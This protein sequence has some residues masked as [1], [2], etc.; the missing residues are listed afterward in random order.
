MRYGGRKFS[1]MVVLPV[2][3]GP[4]DR[5]HPV[6]LQKCVDIFYKIFFGFTN[7]FYPKSKL[8]WER[9]ILLKETSSILSTSNQALKFDIWTFSQKKSVPKNQKRYFDLISKV[10]RTTRVSWDLLRMILVT[11]HV[12]E[13]RINYFRL[14]NSSMMKYNAENIMCNTGTDC[15][16][17]MRK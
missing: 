5:S 9:D 12:S 3:S 10:F 6:N 15:V 11:R 7:I 4:Y 13:C 17:Q 16:V 1:R 14:I 2:F 8:N